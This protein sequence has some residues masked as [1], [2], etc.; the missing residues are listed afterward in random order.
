MTGL[1]RVRVESQKLSSHFESFICK[2][3]SMS[4]HKN[5]HIFSITFLCLE[6][7]PSM[8]KIGTQ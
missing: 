7:A 2:L 4:S 5:I 3:E 8:L 6:M 1:S